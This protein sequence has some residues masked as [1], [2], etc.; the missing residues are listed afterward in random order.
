MQGE[1]GRVLVILDDTMHLRSMRRECWQLARAVSSA[2]VQICVVCSLKQALNR[3]A[4]RPL[5]SQIPE[6]VIAKA[7]TSFE[8]PQNSSCE[9]DRNTLVIENESFKADMSSLWYQVLKFWREPAPKLFDHEAERRRVDIA[10]GATANDSIHQLDLRMRRMLAQTLTLASTSSIKASIAAQ[11]NVKRRSL[12]ELAREQID[13]G[14]DD[15]D[16]I[17]AYIESIFN[18]ECR[19]LKKS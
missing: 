8:D 11:L 19:S 18:D 2:Y 17:V 4:Q 1:T 12:L 7:A 16:K 14:T 10:R 5:A 3:N 15:S 9:W 6:H 13:S